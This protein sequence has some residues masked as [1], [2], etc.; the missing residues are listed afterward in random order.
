MIEVDVIGTPA[1]QGS[2]RGLVIG[3]RAVLVE[4]SKNVK[5]WREAVKQAV[6]LAY[7]ARERRSPTLLLGPVALEVCFRIAKPKKPRYESPGTKPDVDK[8]LRSTLDALK[9]AGVYE[10]DSRV[11]SVLAYKVFAGE[12]GESSLP[13][14]AI[15]VHLS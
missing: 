7:P 9:D 6:M 5:P 10:D 14:A 12:E 4:S 1:P 8:L 11:V 13:G 2:K 15:K 3:D